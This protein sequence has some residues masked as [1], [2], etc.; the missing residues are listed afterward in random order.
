[1]VDAWRERLRLVALSGLG[2]TAAGI[3]AITVAHQ[4]NGRGTPMTTVLAWSIA[5]VGVW[6]V[7]AFPSL[8][9]AESLARRS[10]ATLAL[11]GRHAGLA[12][13]VVLAAVSLRAGIDPLLPA[14][15]QRGLPFDAL[16]M[17][18]ATQ[19][20]APG[21]LAY[22]II[23]LAGFVRV[24]RLRRVDASTVD[25]VAAPADAPITATPPPA[26]RAAIASSHLERLVVRL[27]ARSATVPVATVSCIEASGN[28]ALLHVN[29]RKL[30]ARITLAE[31]ERGL[32]PAR[33]V[34]VHRSAIVAVEAVREVR[35]PRGLGA[36]VLLVN[37]SVV[38]VSRLGRRALEARLGRRA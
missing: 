7:V 2:A 29:G 3:A 37:G 25:D 6:A 17:R 12:M 14:A 9:V 34:R 22:A 19:W 13:L 28:Y 15:A 38:P 16:W 5:A 27:G 10:E 33:F 31:L 8:A 11:A 4:L 32:D 30:T 23:A 26:A 20:L 36:S 21:L 24:G 18:Y 35:A 1:M